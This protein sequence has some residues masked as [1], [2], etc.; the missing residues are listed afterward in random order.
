MNPTQK[1]IVIAWLAGDGSLADRMN[2]ESGGETL[3]NWFYKGM[4]AFEKAGV[5]ADNFDADTS[6]GSGK[7]ILD[8][9]EELIALYDPSSV[10]PEVFEKAA[11]RYG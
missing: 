5:T 11:R 8:R 3:P 10:S 4:E 6:T 9:F 2:A 7:K 1:K